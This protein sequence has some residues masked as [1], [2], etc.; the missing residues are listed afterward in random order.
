MEA[1]PARPLPLSHAMGVLL[2]LL[3]A[4][5]CLCSNMDRVNMSVA[6]LPM[7]TEFGWDSATMGLVQSSFF[8]GYL[9]TQ[10]GLC[11]RVCCAAVADSPLLQPSGT[12][13]SLHLLLSA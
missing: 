6:I 13:T 4:P 9:L 8:W 5:L 12:L 3:L 10:V 1:M 7:K 2:N 11:L